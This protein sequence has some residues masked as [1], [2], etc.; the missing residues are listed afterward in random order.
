VEVRLLEESLAKARAI[1][2]SSLIDPRLIL[3]KVLKRLLHFFL[4]K[5]IDLQKAKFQ[6]VK[7]MAT[8]APSPLFQP[9][10]AVSYLHSFY[11]YGSCAIVLSGKNV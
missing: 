2:Q 7:A 1:S 11:H 8:P 6:L 4:T 3:H 9:S 5:S 10:N